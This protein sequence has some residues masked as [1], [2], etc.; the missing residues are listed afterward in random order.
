MGRKVSRGRLYRC[1]RPLCVEA[2]EGNYREHLG[3][4]RPDYFDVRTNFPEASTLVL[5]FARGHI[6]PTHV[7]SAD[8][9]CCLDALSLQVELL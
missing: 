3:V 9:P 8:W 1:H 5:Q 6:G 7:A 4:R 2:L